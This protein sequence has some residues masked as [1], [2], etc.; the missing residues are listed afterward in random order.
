MTSS[1]VIKPV[2]S[3][4]T[5]TSCDSISLLNYESP[6]SGKA[7]YPYTKSPHKVVDLTRDR[8]ALCP[9][10]TDRAL[11][12]GVWHLTSHPAIPARATEPRP[13]RP[14]PAARSFGAGLG[15]FGWRSLPLGK[16]S[17]RWEIPRH[18]PSTNCW[19]WSQ[20]A[21]ALTHQG[22]GFSPA[23]LGGQTLTEIIW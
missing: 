23:G 5:E 6:P 22:D 8:A 15:P 4:R 16:A 21:P 12:R 18:T 3:A 2:V 9:A 14:A 20:W 10:G 7:F 19:I 1:T 17:L 13:L 11:S